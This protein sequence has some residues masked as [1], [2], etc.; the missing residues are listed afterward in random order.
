VAILLESVKTLRTESKTCTQDVWDAYKTNWASSEAARVL[1][2]LALSFAPFVHRTNQENSSKPLLPPL[3]SNANLTHSPPVKPASPSSPS[4][5]L[6]Q[7]NW[8]NQSQQ[9]PT[10]AAP[11]SPVTLSLP[12]HSA[13]LLTRESFERTQSSTSVSSPRS[14][15]LP[16]QKVP[17][18]SQA[19]ERRWQATHLRE[20]MSDFSENFNFPSGDYGNPARDM[21]SVQ[22]QANSNHAARL[23]VDRDIPMLDVEAR[24]PGVILPQ[25]LLVSNGYTGSY[26]YVSHLPD[27]K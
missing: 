19:A 12:I 7:P 16:A 25:D 18:S 8:A 10:P 22:T 17:L 21:Y 15:D 4:L 11:I 6:E 20:E 14:L 27:S 9:S 23:G 2:E 1:D 24:R 26:W 3:H 5:A 13:Y